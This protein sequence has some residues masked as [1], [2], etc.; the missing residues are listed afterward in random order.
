VA[1][2]VASGGQTRNSA[3]GSASAHTIVLATIKRH[4]L[5]IVQL[6][7]TFVIGNMWCINL[8]LFVPRWYINKR[9][10]QSLKFPDPL[11]HLHGI[12]G[13]DFRHPVARKVVQRHVLVLQRDARFAYFRCHDLAKILRQRDREASVP[14]V[15]FAQIVDV[16]N[17]LALA[18]RCVKA[19]LVCL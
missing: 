4:N 10:P 17:C 8:L 7:G 13:G 18:F 1:F 16:G 14:A 6:R 15:Q 12:L 11:K 19:P 9:I 2:R 5:V 3:R